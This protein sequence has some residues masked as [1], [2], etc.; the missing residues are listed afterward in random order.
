MGLDLC[1]M[2][3]HKLVVVV[4]HKVIRVVHLLPRLGR[5]GWHK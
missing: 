3:L 1:V 2:V 5:Y 4:K